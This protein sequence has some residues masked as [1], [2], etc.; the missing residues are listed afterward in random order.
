MV[1]ISMF[2]PSLI[3]QYD[4]NLSCAQLKGV[5]TAQSHL[6]R[7]SLET[8][9]PLSHH[10]Y[11]TRHPPPWACK[12]KVIYSFFFFLWWWWG[13]AETDVRLL[14]FGISCEN[15]HNAGQQLEACA[16]HPHAVCLCLS[17]TRTHTHKHIWTYT[18]LHFEVLPPFWWD[19]SDTTSP[20][21]VDSEDSNWQKRLQAI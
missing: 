2:G 17:A 3:T 1:L 6:T 19:V 4:M 18:N 21:R 14:P 11:Q 5:R 8:T 7:F 10:I 12:H 15:S 20:H 9:F 16:K 13:G